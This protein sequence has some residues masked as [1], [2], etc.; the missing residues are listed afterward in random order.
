MTDTQIMHTKEENE[1]KYCCDYCYEEI[2][3]EAGHET[4][5][6]VWGCEKCGGNFCSECFMKEAKQSYPPGTEIYDLVLCPGCFTDA[7][8]IKENE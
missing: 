3:W 4:K 5:G 7:N 6:N 2:S 1:M 8:I